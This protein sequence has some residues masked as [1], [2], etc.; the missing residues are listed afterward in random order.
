MSSYLVHIIYWKKHDIHGYATI[1]MSIDSPLTLEA[2]RKMREHALK[3][4]PEYTEVA[5]VNIMKME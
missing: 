1:E 4:N 5:I 3:V 2:T